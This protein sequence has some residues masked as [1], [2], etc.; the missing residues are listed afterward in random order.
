VCG[1]FTLSQPPEVVA[2]QFELDALPALAPRYNIAPGQPVA[3][4][5]WSRSAGRR[6]L[7]LRHWGLVPAWAE[8]P[9]IG[10]RLINARAET[11]S[12]RPSFRDPL[13]RRRCL[14]PADGFYE[15]QAAGALAKRK[16][17]H[18]IGLARGGPFAMAGIWSRWRPKDELGAEPLYSCAI[19][20]TAAN[21]AVAPLHDRM[22]VILPREAE[23]RWLDPALDDDVDALLALLQPIAPDALASHPVSA[24]VNSVKNDDASLLDPSSE[25]P[26]L[27]FGDVL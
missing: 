10:N 22:P 15:W 24:R 23:A 5:R 2:R 19:L 26:Q 4:V 1:R 20:T 25:D 21:A 17:P 12:E 8:D 7:E 3:A 9:A 27:G 18:W 14:I 13:R 6:V 11:A 16:L